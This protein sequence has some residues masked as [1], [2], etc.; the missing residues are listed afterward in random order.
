MRVSCLASVFLGAI[1][2]IA[3]DGATPN[4]GSPDATVE[5]PSP[6]DGSIADAGRS[7]ASAPDSA[8]DAP[9]DQGCPAMEPSVG[10]ACAPEGVECTYGTDP[11]LACRDDAVC[12]GGKW[13]LDTPN[14][15]APPTC[16]ASPTAGAACDT[17]G[18]ICAA[19]STPCA[20]YSC[21]IA[22]TQPKT[23]HCPSL[24]SGCPA[25]SPNFGDPCTN[26][27]L[28]CDYG[29]CGGGWA[30]QCV[31]STWARYTPLCPG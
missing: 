5:A 6:T 14:C 12:M 4:V 15:S 8:T 29:S 11:R 22:C 21:T 24:P 18:E 20:C 25:S 1:S 10:V 13:S 27:G 7:E 19:G 17:L 23:W 31:G 28:I 9:L 26:P 16:P 3:C 30:A 2:G